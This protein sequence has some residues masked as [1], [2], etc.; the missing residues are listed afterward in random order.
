M[1]ARPCAFGISIPTPARNVS[2]RLAMS[3]SVPADWSPITMNDWLRTIVHR[4]AADAIAQAAASSR[5]TRRTER[6]SVMVADR[7]LGSV[8]GQE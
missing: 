7:L 1:A 2:I 6:F 3:R 4:S 5:G 8:L